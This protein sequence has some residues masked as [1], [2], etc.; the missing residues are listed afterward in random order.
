MNGDGL[1]MDLDGFGWVWMDSDGFGMYLKWIRMDW[2]GFRWSWMDSDGFGMG[3]GKS[4]DEAEHMTFQKVHRFQKN[5]HT[6]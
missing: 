4:E 5:F 6:K 1:G 2:D 3:S